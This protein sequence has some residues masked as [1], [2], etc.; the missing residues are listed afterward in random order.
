MLLK[1]G[2]ATVEGFSTTRRTAPL[3]GIFSLSPLLKITPETPLNLLGTLF[4][5]ISC[6]L[7]AIFIFSVPLI[8]ATSNSKQSKLPIQVHFFY[9]NQD[10][11]FGFGS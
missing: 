4:F 6:S 2:Q 10:F 11:S 9:A 3:F 1:K 8:F 7:C 5:H